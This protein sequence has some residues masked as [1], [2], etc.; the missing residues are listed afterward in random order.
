MQ[1][2][3]LRLAECI[4]GW[5]HQD[6]MNIEDAMK[7]AAELRRLHAEN[8][9]L[10]EAVRLLLTVVSERDRLEAQ[11]DELLAA[12][13]ALVK[14]TSWICENSY[15]DDMDAAFRQARAAVAKAKEQQ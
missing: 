10:E 2:E 8:A 7:A 5:F 3:A 6:D 15:G 9:D 13:Q 4:D 11:Q 14:V 1:P 12:L